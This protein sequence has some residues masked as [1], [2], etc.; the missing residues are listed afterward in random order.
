MEIKQ[1]PQFSRQAVDRFLAAVPFYKTVKAQDPWQFEVLLQHSRIVYFA[2]GETVFKHGE[3]GRWLYFL[4]KGQLAVYAAR[5]PETA[6]AV[7]YITPGEVF[8]DLAMLIGDHRTATVVADPNSRQIMAFGTDF[9]AFGPLTDFRVINLKTKLT[10]YRNTVH[11][12][13]WKLEVYRMKYPTFELASDH[14]KVKLYSGPRD[15]TEELSSLHQQAVQ[16]AEL[17]VRWN[18][19]FGSPALG[20]NVP[21]PQVLA[22]I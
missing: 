4:L 3:S 15:T 13:R 19:E 12:L 10:Y 9:T 16:L 11:S 2:P 6:K 7:N 22:S 18:R 17:L 21:S 8:G 20:G 14:H 5:D 1:I